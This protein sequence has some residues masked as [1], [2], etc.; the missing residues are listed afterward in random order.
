MASVNGNGSPFR[1]KCECEI[2][3]FLSTTL[4]VIILCS[5]K[6][7][8]FKIVL[9]QRLTYTVNVIGQKST[10]TVKVFTNRT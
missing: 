9:I 4:L 7:I 6:F 5:T 1:P 10:V 2:Y 8:Q 3:R